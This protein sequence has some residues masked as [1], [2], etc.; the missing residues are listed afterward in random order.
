MKSQNLKFQNLLAPLSLGVLIASAAHSTAASITVL[1]HSFEFNTSANTATDQLGVVPPGPGGQESGNATPA[2][3]TVSGAS[4]DNRWY[5]TSRFRMAGPTHGVGPGAPG[6]TG[7][8][9]VVPSATVLFIR[10]GNSNLTTQVGTAF[11]SQNLGTVDGVFGADPTV[12]LSFDARFG[13]AWSGDGNEAGEQID[14]SFTAT[15]TANGVPY[16]TWTS[17]LGTLA[18]GRTLLKWG[19]LPG[20]PAYL[21]TL[22]NSN[23]FNQVFPVDFSQVLSTNMMNLTLDL[24]KTTIPGGL[25]ETQLGIRFELTDTGGYAG[26][27]SNNTVTLDNVR[28]ETLPATTGYVPWAATNGAS[29]QPSEDTNNDGVANGVAYFMDKTGLA[30]N[31]GINGSGQVTWP[32][33]GNINS[34]EYGPGKQYVVQTSSDLQNWLDV[35]VLDLDTNTDAVGLVDGSLSYTLTGASPQFV[36]LKVTPN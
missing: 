18:Q 27:N 25:G 29:N 15:I 1:N 9:D 14:Q 5:G 26:A 32:N 34:S 19:D 22:P 17:S 6:W 10:L 24:D 16:A 20:S 11:A 21:A 13:V 23:P 12:R 3:W 7:P 2:G 36:R 28:M 4:M 30:T 35:D 31:P 33:G 8:V